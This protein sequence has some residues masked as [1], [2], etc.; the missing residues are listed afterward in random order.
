MSFNT[1]EDMFTKGVIFVVIFVA[2]IISFSSCFYVID[3]GYRGILV[4]LG[5]ADQHFKSEGLGFKLPVISSIKK[6]PI[7]QQTRE[8]VAPCYSSDLQ[9]LSATIKV[10]YRIPESQ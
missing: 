3:P 2:I 10:L 6:I 1:N 4:T 7:K 9:Q 5:R 8:I